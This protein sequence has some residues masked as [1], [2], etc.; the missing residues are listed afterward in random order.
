MSDWYPCLRVRKSDGSCYFILWLPDLTNL[1]KAQLSW[2][3]PETIYWNEAKR[4]MRYSGAILNI[5]KK[6]WPKQRCVTDVISRSAAEIWNERKAT[7][8]GI[9]DESVNI[10]TGLRN[11]T[12]I[13]V[14]TVWRFYNSTNFIWNI[15]SKW[16][17]NGTN[18]SC[19]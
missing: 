12:H 2:T 18:S 11:V 15:T 10:N 9:F 19:D 1:P 5:I 3:L 17:I 6:S 4:W 8:T 16:S 7:Q 13:S 14:H